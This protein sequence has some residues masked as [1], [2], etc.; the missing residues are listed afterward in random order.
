MLT[1]AASSTAPTASHTPSAEEA[2]AAISARQD[3]QTT[4]SGSSKPAQT[5]GAALKCVVSTI[6]PSE[7]DGFAN[8][9]PTVQR[10]IRECL[11]LTTQNLA[12]VYGSA[13]PK[14]G[15]LDCSGFVYRVV[16]S[17]G[18]KSVPRQSNEQYA[19]VRREG[20]FFSVL[21]RDPDTFELEDLEPGD[22]M[23]WTNTYEVNRSIPITHVMI[24]LGLRRADGQRLMV[25]ASEGRR[26][27]GQPQYGVSVFEFRMPSQEKQ[28]EAKAA[29]VGYGRIPGLSKVALSGTTT[30]S[31]R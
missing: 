28:N 15:G 13:D 9:S 10:L 22:L 23:F 17:L 27:R 7:I 4:E 14:N 1:A 12:Y 8:F 21:S 2:V 11:A 25:G 5:Q 29:F 31:R 19:W 24:Y 26:Y 30:S 16:R 6:A 3:A 20:Q 18:I